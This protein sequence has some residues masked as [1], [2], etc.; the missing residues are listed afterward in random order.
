MPADRGEVI[1]GPD[2]F[3]DSDYRPWVVLSDDTHPFYQEE[4]MCAA[5]TRTQR[6][7]SIPLPDSAF[8]SGSGLPQSSYAS[9]WAVTTLKNS[10]VQ[11]TY[12]RLDPDVTD[13][14]ARDSAEYIRAPQARGNRYP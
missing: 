10:D 4:F 14:I 1:V 6:S 13:R 11:H 8:V 5:M 12:G 7:D 9:P 2:P 3:S